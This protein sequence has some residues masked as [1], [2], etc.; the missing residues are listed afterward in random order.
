MKI[1]YNI[2]LNFKLNIGN[3]GLR[4]W[5]N[6]TVHDMPCMPGYPPRHVCTLPLS[7]LTYTYGLPL[8]DVSGQCQTHAPNSDLGNSLDVPATASAAWMRGS[9]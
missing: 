3:I 6:N 1:L 4:S 2:M 8:T 5:V 7:L 9:G